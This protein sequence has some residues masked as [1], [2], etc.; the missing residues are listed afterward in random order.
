MIKSERKQPRGMLKEFF[1]F[2]CS[3]KVIN[4][5]SPETKEKISLSPPLLN[6]SQNCSEMAE[7]RDKR[8]LVQGKAKAQLKQN[9]R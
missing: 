7:I 8:S 1:F 5:S 6:R 4:N 9:D 2:P 3:F